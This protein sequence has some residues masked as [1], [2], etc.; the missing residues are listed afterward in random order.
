MLNRLKSSPFFTFWLSQSFILCTISTIIIVINYCTLQYIGN[1]YFP[2]NTLLFAV[3][4]LLL[5]FG[6]HVLESHSEH[7]KL[8][9]FS[10]ELM[11]FFITM[12]VI[13]YMTNAVQLS[14][15]PLI[16]QKIIAFESYFGFSLPKL[17]AW[18]YQYPR[19]I[20]GLSFSYASLAMQMA[21]IPLI[22]MLTLLRNSDAVARLRRYYCMMLFTTLIGFS[23]YYFFPTAA[24][25][26]FLKSPYF[27]MEQHATGL[28]FLQIRQY[29]QPTTLEGGLIA[30]PSHHTIWAI[31]C[32]YLLYPFRLAFYL[33]L[34]NNI[35]LI[36]SCV[37]L[38]WHYPLDVMAA[39]LI[40]WLAF[41]VTRKR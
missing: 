18:A 6:A 33:L 38:G 3:F 30:L 39:L 19:L 14:P 28:K 27:S 20:S 21:F 5:L 23:L 32:L 4:C 2:Q 10:T 13:T 29:I 8:S 40:T 37:V 35:L 11:L 12:A 15:F 26:T 17:M 16:D 1:N 41:L 24:P 36:L 7:K 22:V 9:I 31:L 25:A 34:A